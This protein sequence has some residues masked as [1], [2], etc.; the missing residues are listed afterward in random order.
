M[1]NPGPETIQQAVKTG[2][3]SLPLLD[4]AVVV[5]IAGGLQAASIA[6]LWKVARLTAR[7]LYT[8]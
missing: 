7:K 3:I 2:I 8:T 6:V 4:F 1:A 5:A